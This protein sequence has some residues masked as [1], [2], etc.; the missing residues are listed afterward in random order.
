MS[1]AVKEQPKRLLKEP[2]FV[3]N[4][5]SVVFARQQ[6]I[7]KRVN[8]FE[9]VLSSSYKQP[10][11]LNIPDDFQPEIP[12]ITFNSTH[13]YSQIV[14]SQISITLNVNYSLDWQDNISLGKSYLSERAPSI[15]E[16]LNT[17][18]HQGKSI[19]PYY[20]GLITL[21]RIPSELDDTRLLEFLANYLSADIKS[22]ETQDIQRKITSIVHNKYFS[23]LTVENY[24][25]WQIDDMP[26]GMIKLPRA[27]A[28]E[29]GIQVTGDFNDRYAFQEKR[30]YHSSLEEGSKITLLGLQQIEETIAAIQERAR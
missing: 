7:R 11:I 24:R 1:R 27:D 13:G 3:Q 21:A 18:K 2:L 16:L 9:D 12:R 28:K 10:Q 4:S 14:I 20:C 25:T 17:I 26:L 22:R 8:S 15:F 19:R 29:R 5:F 23:N 30:S 6:D